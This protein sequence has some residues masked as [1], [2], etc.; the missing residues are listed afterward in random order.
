MFLFSGH[1]YIDTLFLKIRSK[2]QT[3][4][5][6]YDLAMS[7]TIDTALR[8]IFVLIIA[9]FILLCLF[10]LSTPVAN[11]LKALRNKFNN[12]HFSLSTSGKPLGY[13]G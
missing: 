6:E 10:S 8:K 13:N 9:N 5:Q 2:A 4:Q 12:D 3:L 1:F 11:F 7:K